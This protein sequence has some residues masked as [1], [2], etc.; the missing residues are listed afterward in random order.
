MAVGKGRRHDFQLFKRERPL[1]H[2]QAELVADK[3]YQGVQH[4][5]PHSLTPYRRPPRGQLP[6]AQRAANRRLAR[7][8]V[9]VEQVIRCLKVFRVLAGPYRHRRKRFGLRL[10]LLAG[11]HNFGLTPLL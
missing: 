8:R 6:P 3:G 1:L 2:A 5:H 4:L 11:L 7:R 10:R 9:V